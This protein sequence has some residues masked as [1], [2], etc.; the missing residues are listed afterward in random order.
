MTGGPEQLHP[1]SLGES[2]LRI[3]RL[4]ALA[5]DLDACLLYAK[6]HRALA[7]GFAEFTERLVGTLEDLEIYMSAE[8]D[9]HTSL[10]ESL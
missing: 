3:E 8:L 7:G 9:G 10:R 5:R 2:L 6:E 1:I 4:L